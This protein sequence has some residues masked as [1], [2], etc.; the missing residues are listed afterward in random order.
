M[1]YITKTNIVRL[2]YTFYLRNRIKSPP[3][4]KARSTYTRNNFFFFIPYDILDS[5][6]SSM[7]PNPFHCLNK[8][9]GFIF[10]NNLSWKIFIFIYKHYVIV[11]NRSLFCIHFL[12]V[13]LLLCSS[14]FLI[15]FSL[16]FFFFRYILLFIHFCFFC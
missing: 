6:S 7:Y 5:W 12:L 8:K 3:I 15:F 16:L 10:I 11:D 4:Y 2:V 1:K 14:Y 9:F 13:G